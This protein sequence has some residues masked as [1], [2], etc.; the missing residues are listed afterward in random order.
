MATSCVPMHG[1]A[2]AT[3]PVVVTVWV[4]VKVVV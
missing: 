3:D 1:L 4:V 2:E